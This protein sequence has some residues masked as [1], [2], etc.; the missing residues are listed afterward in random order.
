LS[1]TDSYSLFAKY[2][3]ITLKASLKHKLSSVLSRK[4]LLRKKNRKIQVR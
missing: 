1:K 2:K 3:Y 4:S